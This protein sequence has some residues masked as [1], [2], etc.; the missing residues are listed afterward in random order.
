MRVKSE[1]IA[2][3]HTATV[4]VLLLVVAAAPAVHAN[5]FST[6][7]L[8]GGHEDNLSRG[9]ASSDQHGSAYSTLQLRGGK[10]FQPG[11]NTSLTVSGSFGHS[12]YF[13]QKGFDSN[14]LGTA[15]SLEHKF[16]LGPYTPRIALA[17]SADREDLEGAER[18]RSLYNLGLSLSKRFSPAW[19]G[20]VGVVSETSRGNSERHTDLSAYYSTA[21]PHDI[22]DYDN[23]VA[24]ASIEYSFENGNLLTA[25]YSRSDGYVVS[26]AVPPVSHLISNASALAADP[27]FEHRRV[28][29]LLKAE[30]DNFSAGL[31]IPLGRDTSLDMQMNWYSIHGKGTGNY[32]NARAGVSLIHRF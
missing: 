10:L 11:L 27:A 22:F 26:S 21:Q 28:L 18:D 9:F 20:S 32:R 17:L 1:T 19:S 2:G 24:S 31:N 4:M 15:V 3:R 8:G 7:M 23:D 16:G 30:T 12:R 6:V 29:Y 13:S 14:V 5:L 25:S